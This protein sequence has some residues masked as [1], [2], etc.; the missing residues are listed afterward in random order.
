MFS[1]FNS[2]TTLPDR[3]CLGSLL[4]ASIIF[5]FQGGRTLLSPA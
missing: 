2:G 5:F 3:G 1:L 4:M